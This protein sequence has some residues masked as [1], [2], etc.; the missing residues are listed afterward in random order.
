[1]C[2]GSYFVLSRISQLPASS[3]AQ[4]LLGRLELVGAVAV[5]STT[6]G[7]ILRGISL[8][9]PRGGW[10]FWT[11]VLSEAMVVLAATTLLPVLLAVRPAFDTSAALRTLAAAPRTLLAA[12]VASG[13]P[14]GLVPPNRLPSS[15]AKP[16]RDYPH[17]VGDSYASLT[18][19]HSLPP[20][21]PPSSPGSTVELYH[22]TS[23]NHHRRL[24]SG[25][26]D[27]IGLRL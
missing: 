7:T 17:K 19:V 21:P 6:T 16:Q 1:L 20:M 24:D 14:G 23:A 12:G 11:V 15:L 9:A 25:I 4:V 2:F 10:L 5:G 27:D 26:S 18:H 22:G 13:M 3:A 8:L